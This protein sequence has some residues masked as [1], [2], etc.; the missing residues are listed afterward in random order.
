MGILLRTSQLLASPSG[1]PPSPPARHCLLAPRSGGEVRCR[2]KRKG[3]GSGKG[4]FLYEIP[5]D[6]AP[7]L[8]NLGRLIAI[9]RSKP[10]DQRCA[11]HPTSQSSTPMGSGFLGRRWGGQNAETFCHSA[12]VNF[13]MLY[14]GKLFLGQ[15]SKQDRLWFVTLHAA[16]SL[17]LLV[18]TSLMSGSAVQQKQQENEPNSLGS[19][20]SGTSFS[21]A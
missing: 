18:A 5:S 21:G 16:R 19:L 20:D 6:Q 12:I 13:A 3:S 9:G 15:S 10:T 8:M 14:Q 1:A 7:H 17:S 11:R 4:F 2:G